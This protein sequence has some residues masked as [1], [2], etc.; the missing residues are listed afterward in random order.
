MQPCPRFASRMLL[1]LQ[2]CSLLGYSLTAT[3]KQNWSL[4]LG[5][6]TPTEEG[7]VAVLAGAVAW[8]VTAICCSWLEE[9]T[10]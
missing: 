5:Q 4:A 6:R 8:C 1:S 2:P 10:M 9:L 7:D 3:R